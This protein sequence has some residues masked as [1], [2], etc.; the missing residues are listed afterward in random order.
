MCIDDGVV[1]ILYLWTMASFCNGNLEGSIEHFMSTENPYFEAVLSQPFVGNV[2]MIE[3]PV[4]LRDS[5][6]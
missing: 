4:Q 5:Y 6:V 3:A 1:L 2:A